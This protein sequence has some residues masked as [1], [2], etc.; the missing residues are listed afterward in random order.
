MR[1]ITWKPSQAGSYNY[2]DQ[3]FVEQD[4]ILNN[5][6]LVG[7]YDTDGIIISCFENTE[8]VMPSIFSLQ[9]VTAQ[10]VMQLANELAE[11][12]INPDES[13]SFTLIGA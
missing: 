2:L 8:L 9:E 11:F 5:L 6:F 7:D 12:T 13:L 3:W 10:E 1:Y 4:I